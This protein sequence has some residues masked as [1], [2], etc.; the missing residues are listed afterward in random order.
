MML[1]A[2]R[3]KLVVYPHPAVSLQFFE[4]VV[5]YNDFFRLCPEY[6]NELLPSFLDEQ[7]VRLFTLRV[8]WD[9]GLI[10]G[11]RVVGCTRPTNPSA[12]GC[13]TSSAASS[14]TPRRSSRRKSRANSSRT[15]SP[16]CRCAPVPSIS[17]LPS[18]TPPPP[19]PPGLQDLLTITA[20][21]PS[22]EPATEALLTKAAGT[23]SFFDAQLNLFE[24]V[25]TLISILNQVPAQQVVLL[26]A[27]LSPLLAALQ[28]NTRASATTP[29]DFAAV[30]EAHHLIIAVGNVAKGFPDLS[31]R[32]PTA[33]G[34]WVDVYKEATEAVLVSAK[35][36]A[37]FVVIRSAVSPLRWAVR[38]WE[39]KR[40]LIEV[41]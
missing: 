25:G 27:V 38:V 41:G 24:T 26:R 22:D 18:L 35:T 2:C 33:T 14:T 23:P 31:A 4:V 21:L 9:W 36:M 40:A 12:R 19:P 39:A 16:G 11:L 28:A 6:I 37:H 10:L 1:R 8:V 34:Q 29:E 15:S 20:S 3:A 17:S 32:T 30:F 7:C 13:S 5:R